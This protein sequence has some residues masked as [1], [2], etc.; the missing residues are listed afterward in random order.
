[1]LLSSIHV[2]SFSCSSQTSAS[3]ADSSRDSSDYYSGVQVVD[4]ADGAKSDISIGESTMVSKSIFECLLDDANSD[5]GA[6]FC[7]TVRVGLDIQYHN[8]A[9]LPVYTVW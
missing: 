4:R 7:C 9:V 5:T 8:I 6:F 1:M 3:V 2:S